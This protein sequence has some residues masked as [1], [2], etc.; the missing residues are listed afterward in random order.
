MVV[1]NKQAIRGQWF[2]AAL[3]AVGLL[4]VLALGF[5]VIGGL[6][7]P[8]EAFVL[9]TF[10]GALFGAGTAWRSLS[11]SRRILMQ[12]EIKRGT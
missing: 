9:F 12:F 3:R 11:I 5:G 2:A 4:G 8:W 7:L 6:A 10:F 1:A